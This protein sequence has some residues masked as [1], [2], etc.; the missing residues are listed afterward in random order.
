M[1]FM[2]NLEW[3]QHIISGKNYLALERFLVDIFKWV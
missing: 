2:T 1:A 3:M